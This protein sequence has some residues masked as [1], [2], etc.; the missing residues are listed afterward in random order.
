MNLLTLELHI[1]VLILSNFHLKRQNTHYWSCFLCGFYIKVSIFRKKNLCKM[2]TNGNLIFQSILDPSLSAIVSRKLDI[3]PSVICRFS[4]FFFFFASRSIPVEKFSNMGKLKS[5]TT[6]NVN[7]IFAFIF[8]RGDM[9]QK[10]LQ[11]SRQEKMR[12]CLEWVFLLHA[13]QEFAIENGKFS[14]SMP[15][16]YLGII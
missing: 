14:M 13:L 3:F 12:H 7:A 10:L 15:W 9:K 4:L 16:K 11:T 2:N 6:E 5:C 8:I 1:C